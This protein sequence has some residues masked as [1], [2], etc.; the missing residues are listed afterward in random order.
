MLAGH[1]PKQ[2]YEHETGCI[3][4]L[5]SCAN[6]S[7]PH[8]LQRY[9]MVKKMKW[10]ALALS[11]FSLASTACAPTP[12]ADQP[13]VCWLAVSGQIIVVPPGVRNSRAFCAPISTWQPGSSFSESA[14]QQGDATPGGSPST[15]SGET[16]DAAPGNASAGSNGHTSNAAPEEALASQSGEYSSAAPGRATA[17]M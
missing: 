9:D 17:G 1:C 2:A 13:V 8:H 11:V 14:D 5:R 7:P 6:S 4:V 10:Q 15:G 16:S 12:V 3:M